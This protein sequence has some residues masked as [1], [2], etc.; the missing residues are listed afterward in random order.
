MDRTKWLVV[1][2]VD[3]AMFLAALD[4]TVIGTAMPTVVASLGGLDL[5]SWTFSAY[6]LTSTVALP[7]FGS[8]SDRFGRRNMFVVSVW[9]FTAGSALCGLAHGMVFLITRLGPSSSLRHA[10]LSGMIL[11]LGMGVTT[12]T[13]VVATQSTAPRE[14]VGVV[15]S[16]P[17]FFRNIGATIGVAGMGTILNIH[18][19]RVGAGPLGLGEGAGTFQAVPAALRGHLAEGIQAAFWFGLAAVACG[20]LV[21]LL[22]PNLSPTRP[23]AS[24]AAHPLDETDA[25]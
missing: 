1:I 23:G 16:L 11:G 21:S 5:F 13:T 24:H 3:L 9:V 15:S 25:E 2:A 19:Q 18:L 22:V 10:A 7:I 6:L 12:V 4:S 20:V 17:F 8:L 14:K